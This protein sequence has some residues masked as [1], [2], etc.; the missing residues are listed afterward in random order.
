MPRSHSVVHQRANG[1]SGKAAC[2][3]FLVPSHASGA[4]LCRA[5]PFSAGAIGFAADIALALGPNRVSRGGVGRIWR[6][7]TSSHRYIPGSCYPMIYR[8]NS[9]SPGASGCLLCDRSQQSTSGTFAPS[10]QKNLRT[11]R[12]WR[13]LTLRRSC[14]SISDLNQQVHL[15]LTGSPTRLNHRSDR[16]LYSGYP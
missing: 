6:S 10:R 5:G 14:R 7:A 12:P 2:F 13:M 8:G 16:R 1:A 3:C 9:R 15:A 11:A 4:I